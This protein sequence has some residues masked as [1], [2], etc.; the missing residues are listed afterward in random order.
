MV[1]YVKI[2][3]TTAYFTVFFHDPTYVPSLVFGVLI[4][5]G[6]APP[7][8]LGPGFDVTNLRRVFYDVYVVNVT[9]R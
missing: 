1:T 7:Q 8:R 2:W 3:Y 6:S 9:L 5:K 4:T